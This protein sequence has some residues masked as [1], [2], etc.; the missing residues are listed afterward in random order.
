[1]RIL[2]FFRLRINYRCMVT[3]LPGFG[4]DITKFR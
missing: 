2:P 4:N 3:G 1:M